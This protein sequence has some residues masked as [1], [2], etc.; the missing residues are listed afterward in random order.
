[1]EEKIKELLL[2]ECKKSLRSKDV[3]VGAV[4]VRNRKI[5]ASGH[6][7]KEKTHS[8]LGHAEINCINKAARKLRTWHLDD[9]Q[10][11]VTLKPCTICESIIYNSHIKTVIFYLDKPE[12]KKEYYKTN[13][14]EVTN[15]LSDEYKSILKKFFAK[16][17]K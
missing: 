6:N 3:P 7:T 13:F 12:T 16:K 15:G 10:L 8:V 5:I 9:C 17:R 11:Y 14:M 2:K 4:I 1:M